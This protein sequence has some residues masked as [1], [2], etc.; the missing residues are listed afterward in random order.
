M[1]VHE[2]YMHRCLELAGNGLGQ[3]APNPMV[4]S[5]IVYGEEIL[6][7]GYHAVYGEAHAEVNAIGAVKR[8]DLL[9]RSTLYVNLEPC[10]HQGK[11]P[12]CADTIIKHGIPRVVIGTGDPYPEVAGKGIEKLRA[13]GIEVVVNVLE[14][15]CKELNRRFFSFHRKKRPYVILKWAQT[16]DG[17]LG[18]F[19][20]SAEDK[21]I[22][23]E[24]SKRLVH[25]WRSEE[26]AI[27][28]GT[29]T[30]LQDNP[31]L[32]TRLYEGKHPLRVV[33]DRRGRI[34]ASHH[35]LDG[36]TP[37]LVITEMSQPARNNVEH[38]AIDF[39]E[40]PL[41]QIL[42]VLTGKA[43]QSVIVEGG[44]QLLDSFIAANLWD[45]ARVFIGNKTFHE[46][47][48]APS[49]PLN[50]TPG[51]LDEDRLFIIKNPKKQ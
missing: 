26:Q 49:V 42:D 33:L 25:K 45:E 38:A 11:T 1:D 30:A 40:D 19:P 3:V 44:K 46:G 9:S 8:K 32:T 31:H 24:Q 4:G 20:D 43:I 23:N 39:S 13:S 48:P 47:I 2:K 14:E 18:R 34:P 28:V 22:T 10:A 51:R 17:F 12:P 21:W 35:L 5:V 36:E 41:P 15:E 6:G 50:T 29:N 7:E 37:T 27:L 16:L